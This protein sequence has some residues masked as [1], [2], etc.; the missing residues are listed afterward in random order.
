MPR[1]SGDG[2][3]SRDEFGAALQRDA[4]VFDT[5]G[6]CIAITQTSARRLHSL[7]LADE[8]FNREALLVMWEA[9]ERSR[10]VDAINLTQFRAFMSKTFSIRPANVPL[11]DD[12]FKSFD[13]KDSGSVV[14]RDILNAFIQ[15]LSASGVEQAT[16]VSCRRSAPLAPPH[17]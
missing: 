2:E 17:R 4:V 6:D 9:R 3:I 1:Y 10:I 13:T 12:V 14:M 11:V 15:V 16:M 8:G 7:R 5:F